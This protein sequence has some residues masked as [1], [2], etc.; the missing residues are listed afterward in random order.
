MKKQIT[1]FLTF[2]KNNAEEAMNFYIDL[3]DNSK[4]I[5]IQRYDKNG[6]G[7]EGTVIK[8]IFEL[9]GKQFI[10]SDSFIQHE[11]DFTPAISNWVECETAKD[12]EY[13]FEKLSENGDVKMPLDN[14]DFSKQFAFV[15][16][17]FGV[18][19]QLNLE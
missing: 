12:I 2:Q 1:S 18:S 6:P 9:N 13:L 8:A 15:E 16:D 3:F 7:K 5:E 19:W 4:V 10:C 11:W 14:Y 17:R